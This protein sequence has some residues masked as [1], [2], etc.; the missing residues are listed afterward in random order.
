MRPEEF[1]PHFSASQLIMWMDSPRRY[2][3]RYLGGQKE[4]G[5]AMWRGS[6]VEFGYQWVLRTK[7]LDE[8]KREALNL[9][10]LEAAGEVADDIQAERALIEDMVAQAIRWIPPSSLNASQL[11]IEHWLED[12][13]IPFI[14]YVDFCF[15]GLDVDLKTTK[16]NNLRP[17]TT[18]M[19]QMPNPKHIWQVALYRAARRRPGGLLYV[20][21]KLHAFF[22]VTDEQMEQSM[23]ILRQ[24]ALTLIEFLRRVDSYEDAVAILPKNPAHFAEVKPGRAVEK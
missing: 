23:E 8:A 1:T 21:P 4:T 15:D 5:P 2:V 18:G 17:S 6:A 14:G 24:A 22:E 19:I 9:F 10:D 3:D 13:P 12:V 20:T 16:M 7:N 11:K